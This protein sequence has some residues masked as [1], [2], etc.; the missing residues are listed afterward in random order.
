MNTLQPNHLLNPQR[1]LTKTGTASVR[2]S[3]ISLFDNQKIANTKGLSLTNSTKAF[4]EIPPIP[5][6][7]QRTL[8]LNIP[9]PRQRRRYS[10]TRAVIVRP[11][12][13]S[14]LSDE[15]N[16]TPEFLEKMRKSVS[17]INKEQ[18]QLKRRSLNLDEDEEEEHLPQPRIVEYTIV[19][20]N[21]VPINC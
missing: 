19:N 7:K 11:K 10:D 14:R 8:E 21:G 2:N 9:K 4:Q 13:A 6:I 5:F 12:P 1:R 18:D 20:A 17:N 3:S 15:I 16:V